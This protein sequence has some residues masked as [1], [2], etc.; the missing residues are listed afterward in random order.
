MEEPQQRLGL[1]VQDLTPET[2]ERAKVKEGSPSQRSAM[3]DPAP[4]GVIVA[5]VSPGS[6]AAQ[7]GLREG[8]V[9]QE[10]NR[11]QVHS[12][13]QFKEAV[14]TALNEGRGILL[15]ITDGRVSLYVV[16]KPSQE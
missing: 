12:E 10:V 9:I 4:T 6:E 1:T 14:S 8:Y 5:K 3:G 11:R 15:L 16:L 13:P 7:K 2:A